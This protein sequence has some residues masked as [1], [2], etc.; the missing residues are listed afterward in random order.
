MAQCRV[1]DL[2]FVVVLALV[3]IV[4][5]AFD[6]HIKN[7]NRA[8]HLCLRSFHGL[9]QSVVGWT[10]IIR[11]SYIKQKGGC[12]SLTGANRSKQF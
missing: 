4:N 7:K 2:V 12:S 8:E 5:H 1:N 10:F 9:G 11:R 6:L 3:T